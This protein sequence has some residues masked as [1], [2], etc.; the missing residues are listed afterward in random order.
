MFEMVQALFDALR[1]A[2]VLGWLVVAEGLL[3]AAF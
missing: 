3:A 2:E 1:E